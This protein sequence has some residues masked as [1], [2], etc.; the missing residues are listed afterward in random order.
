MEAS[1][2]AAPCAA[3]GPTALIKIVMPNNM[4]ETIAEIWVRVSEVLNDMTVSFGDAV[5]RE[6]GLSMV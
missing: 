1:I 6:T 2:I 5:V 3:A 4:I